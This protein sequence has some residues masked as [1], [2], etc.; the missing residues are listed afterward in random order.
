[1]CSESSTD[2]PTIGLR[3][4]VA[5]FGQSSGL[6]IRW[7]QV[8][9]L[10]GPRRSLRDLTAFLLETHAWLTTT[11]AE[12]LLEAWLAAPVV[13]SETRRL[14]GGM[15]NTVLQ[16]EFDRLPCLVTSSSV[17]SPRKPLKVSVGSICRDRAGDEHRRLAPPE[18]TQQ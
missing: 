6:I 3:G 16:L 11:Q 17:T 9:V 13:C 12:C 4:P 14:E 1:M 15:V 8:Q 5:Q 7:L 10:P 18:P 2:G